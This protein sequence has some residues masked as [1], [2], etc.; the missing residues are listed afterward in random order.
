MVAWDWQKQALLF[1]LM[2]AELN[3]SLWF[4]CSIPASWDQL[5]QDSRK[6]IPARWRT[7]FSIWEHS[8]LVTHREKGSL[9]YSKQYVM[10][11]SI[12]SL[13][14]L[15]WNPAEDKDLDWWKMALLL[16]NSGSVTAYWCLCIHEVS[17]SFTR[18]SVVC[19]LWWF[20]D[21]AHKQGNHWIPGVLGLSLSTCLFSLFN[22]CTCTHSFVP[23]DK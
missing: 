11:I 18:K 9:N 7:S 23:E 2:I 13:G 20:C 17:H 15:T 5:S 8:A 1:F 16:Q 12:R 22:D 14:F 3:G 4:F 21:K 6:L 19:W 10:S